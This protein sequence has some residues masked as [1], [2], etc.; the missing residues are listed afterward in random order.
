M[1]ERVERVER[2]VGRVHYVDAPQEQQPIPANVVMT[3][4]AGDALVPFLNNFLITWITSYTLAV[5]SQPYMSLANQQQQ[6]ISGPALPIVGHIVL[7][8]PL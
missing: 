3:I 4:A 7:Q 8:T 1:T 6:A 2:D 5:N